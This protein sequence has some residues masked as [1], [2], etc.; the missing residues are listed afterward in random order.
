MSHTYSS[1]FVHGVFCTKERRPLLDEGT[2]EMLFPYLGGIARE[3]NVSLLTVGG[4]ED[5]VHL[6]A[7]MPVTLSVA[8][9]M[10]ILKAN[11]SKWLHERWPG[12]S[13]AWQEGYGAFSVSESSRP[14]V[15]AYADRQAEHHRKMSFQE[16]F[17]ALLDKH[18]I[19][20]DQERI[21]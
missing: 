2:R 18:G 10:R 21:W 16:E 14:S 4:T 17:M 11:S 3:L 13:F 20:Y 7:R 15:S 9:M 6:L 5:H 8:D 19:R 12:K 1:L